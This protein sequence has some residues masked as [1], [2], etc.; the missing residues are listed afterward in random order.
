M[1]QIKGCSLLNSA[2]LLKSKKLREPDNNRGRRA[3]AMFGSHAVRRMLLRLCFQVAQQSR[4]RNLV[5]FVVFPSAKVT[6]VAR[7]AYLSCP[8]FGRI[9]K[10]IIETNWG[11]DC[12]FVL[13]LF[14]EFSPHF[15]SHPRAIDGM[16]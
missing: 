14:A 11:K 13:F 9:R 8:V 6:S 1:V 15:F 4:K 5:A 2:P 10:G 12:T 7:A 3:F 16:L